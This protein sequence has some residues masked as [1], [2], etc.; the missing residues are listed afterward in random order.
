M[1]CHKL[2]VIDVSSV[3]RMWVKWCNCPNSRQEQENHLLQSG[4]FPVSYKNIKTTFTFKVL[5]DAR[6]S[7]LE[8][9]SS[10]YQYY[11]KLRRMTSPLFPSAVEV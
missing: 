9:K 4:L 8:C 10:A 2:T 11:Q 6:L 3:H 1:D 5:D 7:N